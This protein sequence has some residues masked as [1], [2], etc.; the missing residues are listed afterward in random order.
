VFDRKDGTILLATRDSAGGDGFGVY[1]F[2]RRP[3]RTIAERS[4]RTL[5]Q[6]LPQ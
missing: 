3:L 2:Y 4:A 6:Q 5:K 1:D